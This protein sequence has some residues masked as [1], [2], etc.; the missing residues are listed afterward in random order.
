MYIHENTSRCS[1]A[2]VEKAGCGLGT[3]LCYYSNKVI[4][5]LQWIKITIIQES[6]IQDIARQARYLEKNYAHYFDHSILFRGPNPAY[7]D[8]V[9]VANRLQQDNQW[10]PASWAPH[11][12]NVDNWSKHTHTHTHVRYENCNVIIT[13]NNNNIM[14]ISLH[15]IQQTLI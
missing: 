6:G 2:Y 7:T 15:N 5:T 1:C 8:V 9:G 11:M 13:T 4:I 10:V 14:I 3:R 12:Y